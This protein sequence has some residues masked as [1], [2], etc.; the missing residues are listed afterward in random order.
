MMRSPPSVSSTWLM[1][2]LHRACALIDLRF[3]F[4]PTNPMNHPMT[5]TMSRVKR[6]SCQEMK[7]SMAK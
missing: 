3:S 6:V 4:L 7:R 2:S 1:V 5:G